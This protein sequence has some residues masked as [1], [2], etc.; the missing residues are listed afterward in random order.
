MSLVFNMVGGGGSKL[1]KDFCPSDVAEIRGSWLPIQLDSNRTTG[2]PWQVNV[3]DKRIRADTFMGAMISPNDY[4][5]L[6][7]IMVSDGTVFGSA[8]TVPLAKE[9]DGQCALADVGIV[10]TGGYVETIYLTVQ[11][12][13]D[14]SDPTSNP[15]YNPTLYV[16]P[17]PTY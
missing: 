15:L 17:N 14:L 16:R 9:I 2:D 1:S 3:V 5:I 8:F 13:Y 11:D 10:T 4:Y 7:I 6:P 12:I